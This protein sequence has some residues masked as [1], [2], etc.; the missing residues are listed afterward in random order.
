[1]RYTGSMTI[2]QY[3]QESMKRS[4]WIRKMF[5]E[6]QRL[7]EKLGAD[8]VADLSL[9]NPVQEP[10]QVLIDRMRQL[11]DEEP[12]GF[13]RYMSNSG[14]RSTRSAVAAHLAK[15]TTVDYV[16][17]NIIMTVGAGGALNVLFK[18][19]L[20]PGDE[21]ICLTPYF[22]E[23]RFYIT[24][25]GGEMVLVPT[26]ERF[27]P[28]PEA[29]QAAITPRTRAVVVNSPNNPSGVVYDRADY[30]ALAEVLH[31]A[32]K[33][34]GRPVWLVSDEPYRGIVYDGVEVPWPVDH[35][36]DTLHVTSFSKDLGLPGERIGYIGIN[37]ACNFADGLR[38]AFTF[39]N[40]TLGFV[41][42][43]AFQQ[44]L[45]EGLLDVT[46]DMSGYIAKRATLLEA[47]A[48]AGYETVR[49]DGAFYIFPKVPGGMDDVDFVNLCLEERLLV[50]PGSGFGTP[51]HFRMSYAVT[52]RDVEVAAE[53]LRR[54]AGR[55]G[56]AS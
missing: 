18:G 2:S 50:V 1:M 25:H 27:R 17:D 30:D 20:D 14:L 19:I 12:G 36:R 49:P 39:T 33:L 54:V 7:K 3:V 29:I 46:V 9:G 41:N 11:V 48:D 56:A 8:Q 40:R 23:Y 52:D 16:A 31:E 43:P 47:L 24:N 26:D 42:A 5:T 15:H 34:Q 35:Y 45:V 51:G 10:P 55:I 44:R 22:V 13:H 21:V 32:S 38:D 53:A 4:S 37:P 28:D 6:G